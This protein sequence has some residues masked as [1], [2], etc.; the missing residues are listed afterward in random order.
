MSISSFSQ[1][2]TLM[3]WQGWNM[4]Q[5]ISIIHIAA[6]PSAVSSVGYCGGS[7]WSPPLFP[8]TAAAELSL[9]A[10]Q[11]EASWAECSWETHRRQLRPSQAT[12]PVGENPNYIHLALND[13]IVIEMDDIN[14][15]LLVETYLTHL[16]IS[17]DIITRSQKVAASLIHNPTKTPCCWSKSAWCQFK[18]KHWYRDR[19]LAPKKSWN[20]GELVKNTILCIMRS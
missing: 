5:S 9:Q 7:S 6:S 4:W 15:M 20:M 2:L 12:K 10:W 11:E 14:G 18:K 19:L 16:L 8:W 13:E 17:T 1:N 3:H